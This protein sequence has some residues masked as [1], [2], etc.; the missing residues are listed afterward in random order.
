VG[1][2]VTEVG[3]QFANQPRM[4]WGHAG[5]RGAAKSD[6]VKDLEAARIVDHCSLGGRPAARPIHSRL[7]I[8]RL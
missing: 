3:F 8:A 2:V 1:V 5:V 6:G 7:S 4:Q